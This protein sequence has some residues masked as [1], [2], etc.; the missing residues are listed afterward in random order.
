MPQQ[1]ACTPPPLALNT[2]TW[3]QV[4][5]LLLSGFSIAYFLGDSAFFFFFFF[6]FKK[7]KKTKNKK[8]RRP[9]L[10]WQ[11]ARQSVFGSQHWVMDSVPL[12]R[13]NQI[14]ELPAQNAHGL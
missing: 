10:S 14:S 6:F 1:P 9:G 3:P 5:E 4:L 2:L 11:G 13:R 12:P 7:K 8:T